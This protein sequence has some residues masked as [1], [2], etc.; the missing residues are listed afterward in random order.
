VPRRSLAVLA[1]ALVVVLLAAAPAAAGPLGA[2][3]QRAGQDACISKT[4]S[5][6]GTAGACR[7]D[8]DLFGAAT[9]AMAPDGRFVYAAGTSDDS[10]TD[11]GVVMYARDQQT[12]LLSVPAGTR[13]WQAQGARGC[14]DLRGRIAGDGAGALVISADGR[15]AYGVNAF[16][17]I[18]ATEGLLVFSR[19]PVTGALSQLPG[20]AGCHSPT[21]LGEEGPGAC[22]PSR[23]MDSPSYARISADDRFVYVTDDNSVGVLAYA[24]DPQTGA[25]TQLPGVDGCITKDGSDG[26][27]PDRCRKA[28][29][30]VSD[31]FGPL[32]IT[33]DGRHAYQAEPNDRVLVFER[34]PQTG[35]LSAPAGAG[36]C[37]SQDASGGACADGRALLSPQGLAMGRDGRTLYVASSFVPAQGVAALRIDPATGALSQLPGAAGCVTQNGADGDGPGTTCGTGQALEG[38]KRP[39]LSPDGR[40]LHVFTNTGLALFDV[41]VASGAPAQLAGV[42]GCVTQ[43]GAGSGPGTCTDGLL[44]AG[45]GELAFSP[46][47]GDVYLATAG[48]PPGVALFA[49][50]AAPFCRPVSATTPFGT[51][52]ALTLSCADPNGDPVLSRQVETPPAGALGPIGGDGVAAFTPAAGFSGLDRFTFSATSASGTGA[53]ATATVSVGASPAVPPPAPGPAAAAPDTVKPVARLRSAR[54]TRRGV[55][56][57]VGLSE[58]AAVSATLSGRLGKARRPVTLATGQGRRATAGTVT[59]ALK[60]AARTRRALLGLR[61]RALTRFRGTLRLVATDAAG[62]RATTA[63]GAVRLRR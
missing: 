58:G 56:L 40:T 4:G 27:D 7:T 42:D 6:E 46:E 51:P 18:P 62:N 26:S 54:I 60:P 5:G 10:T 38:S 23:A 31:A 63:V 57:V 49:R 25:L 30:F 1:A 2:L 33:P 50:E 20:T 41:D 21:G 15:S 11:P 19:D 35:V 52:V 3:T 9:L 36:A 44:V 43:S 53:P 39:A 17:G 24:R 55:T 8:A 47:G 37:M 28:P 14:A 34:D 16:P 61:G 59:L 12:G 32:A 22:T 45:R 48:T 13:C 29:A